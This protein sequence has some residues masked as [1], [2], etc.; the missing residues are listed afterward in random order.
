MIGFKSFFMRTI[1]FQVLAILL[2]WGLLVA[3]VKYWYYP[4]MEKYF[5]NQQRI[6]AAGIANILDETGTDN[7]DYRGIIKTIEGMYIDSINNGMQDEIDYH[8]LF[9][10]YD[11]DN[12]VL[13]QFANA[14]RATA[15]AA[16]GAVRFRQ[17]RRR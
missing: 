15:P 9:V 8:P 6:V 11:R 4:D 17:L 5:D 12:R 2:L 14:G 10:V 16:F 13:L 1:I 7:I 3:W